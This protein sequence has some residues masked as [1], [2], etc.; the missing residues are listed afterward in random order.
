M[1]GV[2]QVL[3]FFEDQDAAEV[4]PIRQ[5]AGKRRHLADKSHHARRRVARLRGNF[6]AE[7]A[8]EIVK[9]GDPAA[10][11]FIGAGTRFLARILLR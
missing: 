8:A 6:D 9:A 10:R 1:D 2:G 11:G 3:S 5:Y 7:H 4:E